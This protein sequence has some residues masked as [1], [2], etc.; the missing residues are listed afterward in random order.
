MKFYLTTPIYYVND[1]PH[2]GH[3]YTTI[4]ADV[5]SRWHKMC[6]YD[7]F[8][9]TGTDEHGLKI[10]ESAKN[11]NIPVKQYCDEI[12][13][14]FK[15]SWKLLNISY[16]GFIR[17]TDDKH[18]TAV[19]VFI[20]KL[21]ENNKI[22]KKKY[23]G[24]YCISCE[25][26]LTE[27]ELIDGKCP[28][29]KIAPVTHEEENYF[30]K[31]SE[32]RDTLINII[33]DSSHPQHIDIL[34][35]SRKN[36]I[37][38][39]LKLGLDDISISREH[40]PWGI[41]LPFDKSQTLY[42]WIDALLNYITAIEYGTDSWSNQ[43]LWPAD[44]HLMAK[45]IL[46]FHSVIWPAM[47]LAAGLPVP[48]KLFAHGFFTVNGQKMSKTIG[49]VIQP[50]Q[51]IERF[52][53]DATRYLLL[54]AFPFGTDGDISME[55]MT[56]K[57]NSNLANNIGNLVS[58]T[59]TM[60]EKYCSGRIPGKPGN[61]NILL[62]KCSVEFKDIPGYYKSL[63]FSKI[64]DSIQRSVNQANNYVG[65]KEPWNLAKHDKHDELNE[66]LYNLC[67]F[68]W[69]L[70]HYLYPIMPEISNSI[71]QQIGEINKAEN[72][73]YFSGSRIPSLKSN[74][75]A[76]TILFPRK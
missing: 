56:E 30:F 50:E 10:V 2:I 37:L 64:I 20:H 62:E 54:S 41:P 16:D 76:K 1:I 49:N 17:T 12:S 18:I 66:V 34:P 55:L 11:K 24:L 67:E 47:L 43:K 45:D 71:L 35:E 8:F 13:G 72:T 31:L 57:Y 21:H 68:I 69:V 75:V 39:K 22:Y 63:E 6:G 36:E 42:V 27:T 14:H 23:T 58:R 7:V 51:L 25:R 15:Q 3:A 32:Y 19:S 29:H 60:V 53:V 48:G 40:L 74:T 70:A 44:L 61:N 52:G 5:L 9:L 59:V 26:F 33:S 73:K 4:A 38:G 65:E 28:D 46:W